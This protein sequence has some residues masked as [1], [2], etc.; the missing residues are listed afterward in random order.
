ME[1]MKDTP[2]PWTMTFETLKE[3]VHDGQTVKFLVDEI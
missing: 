2:K 1:I 3:T